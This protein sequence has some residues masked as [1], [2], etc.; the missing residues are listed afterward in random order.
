MSINLGF[1]KV[2]IMWD[3]PDDKII[4]IRLKSKLLLFY[5]VPSKGLKGFSY[6]LV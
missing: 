5:W 4:F 2:N 1:C 3:I 6:E